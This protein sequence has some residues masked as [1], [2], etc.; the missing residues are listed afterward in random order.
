MDGFL[1]VVEGS[2]EEDDVMEGEYGNEVDI[3]EEDKL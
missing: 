1:F 2:E 3:Y